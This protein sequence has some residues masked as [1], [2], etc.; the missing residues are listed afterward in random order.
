[1]HGVTTTGLD[2]AK[3]VF[4]VHGIDAEGRAQI[5]RQLRRAEPVRFF[6]RLPPCLVGMG[7]CAPA[8]HWVRETG[9][10]GHTVKLMPPALREAAREAR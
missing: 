5:R 8:H 2:L 7:A 4:Q 6:G 1:M 9:A 3:N 10:F